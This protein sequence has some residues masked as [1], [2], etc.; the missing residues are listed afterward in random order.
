[1]SVTKLS[2][3]SEDEQAL[4]KGTVSE[5]VYV[6]ETEDTIFYPQGGGQP[7]DAGSFASIGGDGRFEVV[8]VRNALEKGRVLHFGTFESP[9]A[10]FGV[11]EE[12]SDLDSP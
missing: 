2:E 4:F 1:V 12:V 3:I 9:E 6:L 8:I 10:V 7:S 5:H 11:N